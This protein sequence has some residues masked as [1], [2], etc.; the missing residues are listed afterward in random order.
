M[1]HELFTEQI[2][3]RD[4]VVDPLVFK[5]GQGGFQ[6]GHCL[7]VR[8][9]AVEKVGIKHYNALL[10]IFLCLLCKCL[11]AHWVWQ[12][13][14]WHHDKALTNLLRNLCKDT[15]SSPKFEGVDVDHREG[16]LDWD[17]KL[18]KLLRIILHHYS[19]LIASK[20]SRPH[21]G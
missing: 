9:L 16:E 3:S 18:F 4:D 7:R 6:G 2:L 5:E 12:L 21:H 14:E 10:L 19:L 11:Q 15:F 20:N 8:P 1:I 17:L 13:F